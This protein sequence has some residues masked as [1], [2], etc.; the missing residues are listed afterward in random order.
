MET[1]DPQKKKKIVASRLKFLIVMKLK[2]NIWEIFKRLN[3]ICCFNPEGFSVSFGVF[4]P[5]NLSI[6]SF[7][8]P[9]STVSSRSLAIFLVLVCKTA[10]ISLPPVSQ[11][12]SRELG[13]RAT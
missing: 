11:V 4:K 3:L 7:L 2:K 10:P 5:G 1:R 12:G 6:H 8:P 9:S 13:R